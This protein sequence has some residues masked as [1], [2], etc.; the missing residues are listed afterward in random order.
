GLVIGRSGVHFVEV[1][2]WGKVPDSA[3]FARATRRDLAACADIFC[4]AFSDSLI[5]LFGRIPA[6]KLIKQMFHLFMDAEADALIVAIAKGR[7]VGYVYAPTA[8]RHVWRAAF[9]EG[10]VRRWILDWI[11]GRLSLGM[12]PIRL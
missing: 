1:P 2:E 5:H 12:A 8:L 4:E 7:V 9:S 6:R 3:L 11:R 10:H